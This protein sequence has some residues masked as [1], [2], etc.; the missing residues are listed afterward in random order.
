MSEIDDFGTQIAR[1]REDSGPPEQAFSD[2]LGDGQTAQPGAAHGEVDD[3]VAALDRARS[4]AVQL[5]QRAASLD[6][7]EQQIAARA[8]EADAAVRAVEDRH[9]ALDERERQLH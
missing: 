8:A 6:H 1:A 2:L 3:L 5:A 4:A 9:R 7:E